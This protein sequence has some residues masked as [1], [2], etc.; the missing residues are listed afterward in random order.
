MT[1]EEIEQYRSALGDHYGAAQQAYNETVER[2]AAVVPHM[3]SAVSL[4][5]EQREKFSVLRQEMTTIWGMTNSLLDGIRPTPGPG[6]DPDPGPGPNPEPEPEPE[7][8]PDSGDRPVD[9]TGWQLESVP[10]NWARGFL[11]KPR[12]ENTEDLVV[13]ADETIPQPAAVD[14]YLVDGVGAD[15]D[16]EWSQNGHNQNRHHMRTGR[17]GAEYPGPVYVVFPIEAP[18]VYLVF[19]IDNPAN[20]AE[21]NVPGALVRRP[22]TK[23]HPPPN[24]QYPGPAWLNQERG[25]F[26]HEARAAQAYGCPG[27]ISATVQDPPADIGQRPILWLLHRYRGWE[28]K[29]TL[30]QVADECKRRADMG[31]AGFCLNW[32]TWTLDYGVEILKTMYQVAESRG[33]AFIPS[34]KVDGAPGGRY[35]AGL[36][37]LDAIISACKDYSHGVNPWLYSLD[38]AQYAR[39]TA[40]WERTGRPVWVM[41]DASRYGPAA[42]GGFYTGLKQWIPSAK[43]QKAAG[44]RIGMFIPYH[45]AEKN[46]DALAVMNSLYPNPGMPG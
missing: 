6:P 11:W 14:C 23:P 35:P 17:S 43:A 10:G 44:K 28:V 13:L 8:P 19:R 39:W 46:P 15:H 27:C 3:T 5:T 7:P 20:R 22:T 30:F 2:N 16:T 40:I 18:N 34:P 12:G 21:G 42:G 1:R 45:A 25:F 32:E 26:F 24:E 31:Y 36:P 37:N 9:F 33:L 29:H 4:L 38:P 41:G